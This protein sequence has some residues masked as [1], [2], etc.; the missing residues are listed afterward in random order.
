M[1]KKVTY[2]RKPDKRRFP[3]DFEPDDQ[4]D[5]SRKKA[6]PD[7]G[8]KDESRSSTALS[9]RQGKRSSLLKQGAFGGPVSI[10]DADMDFDTR[11]KSG[12]QPSVF[13]RVIKRGRYQAAKPDESS[14]RSNR[15]DFVEMMNGHERNSQL[16]TPPAESQK[17]AHQQMRK[18]E[19]F[20]RLSTYSHRRELRLID[21]PTPPTPPTPT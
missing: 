13:D 19:A 20:S 8:S 11:P 14:V 9:N 1:V 21:S 7:A 17:K 4:S 15:E 3:T 6:R 16:P 5:N 18:N 10:P 12:N 2:S